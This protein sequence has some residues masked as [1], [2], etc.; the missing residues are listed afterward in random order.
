MLSNRPYLLR[1]FHQWIVDSRCTPIIVFDANDPN[2][3]VPAGYA[4][5]GE[6][7]FNISSHAV[8]DLKLANDCVEFRASFNGVV[9][10]IHAPIKAVLAIYAEENNE[11][12]F[13]DT[14]DEMAADE[15]EEAEAPSAGALDEQSKPN[16]TDPN[17]PKPF[18]KIV[19]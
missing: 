2:C 13:F 1:A 19:K 12:L 10:L 18:L 6:I 7:V 4:E 16:S 3:K 15:N 5:D 11:G 9:H 17:R 8:R 14:E